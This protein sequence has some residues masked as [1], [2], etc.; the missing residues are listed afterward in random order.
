MIE[1]VCHCWILT[2]MK[3][4][5]TAVLHQ[6]LISPVSYIKILAITKTGATDYNSLPTESHGSNYDTSLSYQE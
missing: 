3:Q 2:S 6:V 4:H 1:D 5:T